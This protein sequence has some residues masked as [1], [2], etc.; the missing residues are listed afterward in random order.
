MMPERSIIQ[1]CPERTWNGE[2]ILAQT[3]SHAGFRAVPF[4][5]R[6]SSLSLGERK[7]ER[8]GRN[9]ALPEPERVRK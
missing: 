6:V 3:H 5:E 1:K 7:A 2:R 9:G 4:L 8:K